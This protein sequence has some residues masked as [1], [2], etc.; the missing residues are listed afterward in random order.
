MLLSLLKAAHIRL[1]MC[2]SILLAL[3]SI[4]GSLSMGWVRLR[5]PKALEF[6]HFC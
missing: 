3:L 6:Q 5:R 1:Q 2:V 4:D